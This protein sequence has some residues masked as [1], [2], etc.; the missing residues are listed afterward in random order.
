MNKI[1]ELRE[2]RAKLWD[3]AKAFLDTHRAA[4]DTMSAEDHATYQR[5][6]NEVIDLGKQIE[7]LERRAAIESELA[8]FKKVREGGKASEIK[9]A[10]EQFQQKTYDIFGKVYAAAQQAQ[11]QPG[12]DMGGNPNGGANDDGTVEGD[13]TVK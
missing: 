12:P 8:A 11:Q 13:Y 5:M 4:D 7:S 9:P 10:M 1:L 6:E 2:K 3:A